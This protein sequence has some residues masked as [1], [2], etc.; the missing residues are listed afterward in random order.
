MEIMKFYMPSKNQFPEIYNHH[1]FDKNC[2][3]DAGWWDFFESWGM[4]EEV[5]RQKIKFL[6]LLIGRLTI[7]NEKKGLPRMSHKNC[8]FDP[9]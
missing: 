4:D 2:S 7:I 8:N 3:V 6:E 1:L 5:K 9:Y